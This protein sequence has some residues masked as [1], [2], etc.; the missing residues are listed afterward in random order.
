M[1]IIDKW[2][3]QD[4]RE[5][6]VLLRQALVRHAPAPPVPTDRALR[7]GGLGYVRSSGLGGVEITDAGL[8]YLDGHYVFCPVSSCDGILQRWVYL[9]GDES[10]DAHSNNP[11]LQ[12]HEDGGFYIKCPT[13]GSIHV[14]EGK[15]RPQSPLDFRISRTHP[16]SR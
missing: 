5:Y 4:D 13:C 16:P 3:T 10:S 8:R 2:V 7:L 9:P 12:S 15:R 1:P 11:V 14:L 6:L